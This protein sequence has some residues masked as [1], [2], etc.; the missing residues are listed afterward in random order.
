[1]VAWQLAK[2]EFFEA[3]A[4]AE[5]LVLLVADASTPEAGAG[6]NADDPFA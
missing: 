4:L 1:M 6:G 2:Q 5:E 3:L